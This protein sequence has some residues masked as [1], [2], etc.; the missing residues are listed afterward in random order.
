MF[1][2]LHITSQK[3]K[4]KSTSPLLH[5]FHALLYIQAEHS[6]FPGAA[7]PQPSASA[8]AISQDTCGFP[9]LPGGLVL[10]EHN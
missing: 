1:A 7:E 2:H 10:A 6:A 3:K 4:I 9:R 5:A 8:V